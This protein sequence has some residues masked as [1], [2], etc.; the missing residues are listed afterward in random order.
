MAG[1]GARGLCHLSLELLA[2]VCR[3]LRPP[4]LAALEQVC[5]ALRGK[6]R[7]AALWRK[8]ARVVATMPGSFHITFVSAMARF[9][10]R[11][12]LTDPKVYKVLVA[13]HHL[14]SLALFELTRETLPWRCLAPPTGVTTAAPGPFAAIVTLLTK[15]IFTDSGAYLDGMEVFE[16]AKEAQVGAWTSRLLHR[17]DYPQA[18]YYLHEKL[19]TRM[20]LAPK[21]V[22]VGRCV[23][24]IRLLHCREQPFYSEDEL[25][26]A[27]IIRTTLQVNRF[28]VRP[29]SRQSRQRDWLVEPVVREEDS[30]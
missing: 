23:D 12:R 14:I 22:E 19:F 25:V 11:H 15:G 5:R 18:T 21:A 26:M 30:D 6:V 29:S 28:P 1:V 16:E 4:H 27:D 8:Q 17:R 20:F 2:M 9:A 10:R 7:E 24:T 3:H 13:A